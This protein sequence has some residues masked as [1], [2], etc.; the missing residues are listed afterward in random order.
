[1][2]GIRR[3][4]SYANVTATIAL[5]IAIA[6][7]TTAIA[8]SKG[9]KSPDVNKKGNIR[10]GHVTTPKLADGSVTA[11]KIAGG[12]VTAG[13][14]AGVDVVQA[15]GTPT[16][17]ATCPS[18]ERLVSGGAVALTGGTSLGSSSPSE[19]GNGWTASGG[20]AGGVRVVALCLKATAGG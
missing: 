17:T 3:H 10:A 20:G 1:M 13:Q 12:N 6:G 8:V 19:A 15:T 9:A 16:S 5:V 14:L 4:L 18:G 2:D 11:S 7:G